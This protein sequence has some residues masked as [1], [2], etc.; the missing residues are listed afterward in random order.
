MGNNMSYGQQGQNMGAGVG[1]GQGAG[2]GQ[3]N[4]P[5]RPMPNVNNNSMNNGMNMNANPNPYGAQG[6]GMGAGVGQNQGMGAGMQHQGANLSNQ[7][8]Q[9]QRAVSSALETVDMTA[10][11][12]KVGQLGVKF[13][14]YIA[15]A[16]IMFMGGFSTCLI[17]M[18]IVVAVVEKD[19]SL[20][21]IVASMLATLI[22]LNIALDVWSMLYTPISGGISYIIS[23]TDYHGILYEM[24]DKLRGVVRFFDSTVRYIYHGALLFIGA[25][26]MKKIQNGTYKVSK[27]IAKYF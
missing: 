14:V 10:D 23:G 8:Q 16:N 22:V 21:K 7:M 9:A 15:L 24:S 6:Q 25:T 11:F 4:K 26:N 20:T 5:T 2:M 17:A 13:L 12:N 18:F 27:Y 19:S 3:M 1:G